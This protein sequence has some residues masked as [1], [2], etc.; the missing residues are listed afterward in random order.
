[1]ETFVAYQGDID[2]GGTG[3]TG[4]TVVYDQD[5]TPQEVLPI[6]DRKSVV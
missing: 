1:M 6:A 3:F 4:Q 5:S 2:G